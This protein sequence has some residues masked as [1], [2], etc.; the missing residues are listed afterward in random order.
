MCLI[1]S[2]CSFPLSLMPVSPFPGLPPPVF[3]LPSPSCRPLSAQCVSAMPRAPRH[4]SATRSQASVRAAPA[5]S[6][7]C[8]TGASPGTGASPTAS[9]ASAAGWPRIATRR[10]APASTARAMQPETTVKG[11][12]KGH[13]LQSCATALAFK[14][15]RA[16]S[17]LV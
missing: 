7:P 5:P 11:K 15:V 17:I 3:L 8:V 6:G 4:A 14:S 2:K 9:R 1:L 13:W 16:I 10:R 12:V